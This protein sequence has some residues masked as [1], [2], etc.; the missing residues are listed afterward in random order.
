MGIRREPIQALF[1]HFQHSWRFQD[2]R[3]YGSGHIHETWLIRTT[4]QNTPD[5]ILQK[6]NNFV[7]RDVPSLMNNIRSVCTHLQKKQPSGKCLVLL[8]TTDELPF[9][10]DAEGYYWRLF[11]FIPESITC[12]EPSDI[13]QICEAGKAIGDFQCR[14]SDLNDP[15]QITIPFF[16]NLE[17]RL[18]EFSLA[19]QTDPVK[20]VIDV[21]REI[22]EA[23]KIAEDLKPFRQAVDAGIFPER[24]T[25]NDT[26]LINVLFD[27]NGKAIC[28]I[29]L[30]TVMPGLIHYDF[31]DA[32]RT[33]ANPASEDERDLAKITFHMEN[34]RALTG[35]Y[36]EST[37]EFLT[38]EEKEWL[39][40]AAFYMTFIIGLRF[41]TDH[42][43]GD[44]YFK[45]QRDS[46]NLDRARVQFR[47]IN[48]MVIYRNEMK[49]CIDKYL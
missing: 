5:Y 38:L 25:H 37:K 30:D 1:S 21:A 43:S 32:V 2:C 10:V 13:R 17:Y 44:V 31:G 18:Q 24:I 48:E 35:G 9:Y 34:F 23:Y 41:L 45:T 3:P 19:V 49:D 12:Q 40:E 4:G 22:E 14:L 7:F 39:P 28:M 6:I 26:K 8:L 42:I 15:V 36:L 27:K 16:H 29:D 33:M 20:R 47:F 11:E 46:Q